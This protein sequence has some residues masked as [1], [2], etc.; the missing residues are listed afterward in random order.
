RREGRD[1]PVLLVSGELSDAQRV[2]MAALPAVTA[3]GK[4][5]SEDELFEALR[6]VLPP[7]DSARLDHA[8]RR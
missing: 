1:V 8:E 6:S 5:F 4:P 3:L 2:A 7:D